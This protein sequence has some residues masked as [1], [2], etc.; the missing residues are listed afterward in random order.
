M[1]T[2]NSVVSDVESALRLLL[3]FLAH[4]GGDIL[5]FSDVCKHYLGRVGE[6]SAVIF[7]VIA[8]LGAAAVYWVLM[9]NFLYNIVYFIYSKCL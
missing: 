5:E 4:Q 3:L 2:L 7:S 6:W 9:S 8:L 1:L